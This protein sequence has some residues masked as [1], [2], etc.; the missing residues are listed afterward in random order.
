MNTSHPYSKAS[1]E[2]QCD[3]F[4]AQRIVGSH[5]PWTR[6]RLFGL[7]SPLG[8]E[9]ETQGRR[10]EETRF[11]TVADRERIKGNMAYLLRKL[12]NNDN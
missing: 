12:L 8:K 9:G 7:L 4:R 5:A 10:G 6:A 1:L 3:D 11:E 2:M